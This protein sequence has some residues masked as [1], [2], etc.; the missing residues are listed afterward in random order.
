MGTAREERR[1]DDLRI[2][3]GTAREDHRSDACERVH[4]GMNLVD[5]QVTIFP[6][7]STLF[8]AVTYHELFRRR[9]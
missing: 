5:Q 7:I 3:T 4:Y 8:T 6:L 2:L 1:L 9:H